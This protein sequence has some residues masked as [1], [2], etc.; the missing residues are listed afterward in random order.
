M[1]SRFSVTVHGRTYSF[2]NG[3]CDKCYKQMQ[4]FFE[5]I[6]EQ[7]ELLKNNAE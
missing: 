4:P 2:Y 7:T 3:E 1:I 5:L 6:F